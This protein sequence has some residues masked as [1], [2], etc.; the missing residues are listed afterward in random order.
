MHRVILVGFAQRSRAVRA[1]GGFYSISI[2]VDLAT[3]LNFSSKFETKGRFVVVA[4]SFQLDIEHF[5]KPHRIELPLLDP[6]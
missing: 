4:S 5:A 2:L 6:F 3:N 1:H